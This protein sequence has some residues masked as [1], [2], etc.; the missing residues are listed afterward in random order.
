M[1][2]L[3]VFTVPKNS[4]VFL[5]KTRKATKVIIIIIV[6]VLLL[7]IV[8]V[9]V[10]LIIIIVVVVVVVVILIIIYRFTQF[11]LLFPYVS[12]GSV[13][14]RP[15]SPCSTPWCRRRWNFRRPKWPRPSCFR[16]APDGPSPRSP[17]A[18]ATWLALNCCYGVK[19]SASNSCITRF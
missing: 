16:S 4:Q 2:T 7:L 15:R 10:L 9:V 19:Y 8:V 12:H 11:F 14:S 18:I 5:K 3:L 13:H 6:V 17:K 1:E